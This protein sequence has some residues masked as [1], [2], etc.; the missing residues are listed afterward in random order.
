[1]VPARR[2]RAACDA[3]WGVHHDDP[4]EQACL[5]AM[6]EATPVVTPQTAHYGWHPGS[7][8][9]AAV[10]FGAHGIIYRQCWHCEPG[11]GRQDLQ[12]DATVL[13]ELDEMKAELAAL[14]LG[15]DA[16]EA[17]GGCL[18]GGTEGS[19]VLHVPQVR[20]R[21]LGRC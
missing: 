5:I 8:F 19:A 11:F 15:V 2:L 14:K 3:S 18:G 9:A 21:T 4:E 6:G 12:C 20:R 10:P 7:A 16:R 13:L 1:M 17:S